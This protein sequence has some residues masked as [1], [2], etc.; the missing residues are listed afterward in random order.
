MADVDVIRCYYII[1]QSI[2]NVSLLGYFLSSMTLTSRCNLA[3]GIIPPRR[4][5]APF[6]RSILDTGARGE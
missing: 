1:S 2:G 4:P 3:L 6:L 5:P